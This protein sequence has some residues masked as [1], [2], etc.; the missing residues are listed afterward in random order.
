MSGIAVRG[1]ANY[2]PTQGISAY[3][4]SCSREE[5]SCAADS[6]KK[7]MKHLYKECIYVH[8]HAMHT[9]K[10]V[11][12]SVRMECNKKYSVTYIFLQN[13]SR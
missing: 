6:F 1:G 10:Q 4:E 12:V 8:T 5:V 13:V 3:G 9:D 2:G 7:C 11:C